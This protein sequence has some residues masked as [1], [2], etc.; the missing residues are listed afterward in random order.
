MQ[1]PPGAGG[2]SP[3]TLAPPPL[4]AEVTGGTIGTHEQWFPTVGRS[5]RSPMTSRTAWRWAFALWVLGLLGLL[6]GL[7]F[8]VGSG[9]SAADGATSVPAFLAIGTVGLLIVRRRPDNPIGWIY[10]GTW[11]GVGVAIGFLEGYGTWATVAHPGVPGGTLAVWLT[12][13]IWIPI[14]VPLVTYAFLLFPDGHVPSPR[15][16]PVAWAIPVSTVLWSVTFAL[17]GH[18]YTDALG[19]PAPNPYGI[20][21]LVPFFDAARLVFGLLFV[22]LIVASV[23][24]LFV[25][26]R[27]GDADERQQLKWLMFAG[28]IVAVWFALPL[29]HGSG[30]IADQIQG[31][32]LMLIPL[33][34][35]IAITKYHLYDIDLVVSKTVVVGVM[36]VFITLV[37]VGVVVGVGALVGSVGDPLLSAIAAALVAL[38]FQPV[39]RA[40][41]RLADRVVY[42]KR[43]TPYEV[44]AEFSSHMGETFSTEDVLQRMAQVLSAGTGAERATVWLRIQGELRPSA[45]WP[46]G[47]PA[48][49]PDG[50]VEVRDRGEALGALAIALPPSDPMDPGK[51]RLVRDL[52]SQAGLVLRNVRLIEELRASR[53]RLVAAQDAERR[54]IERNIHDGA[55]QD[56]VALAVRLRLA[57]QLSDRD[58]AKV[59]ELLGE[60]QAQTQ[61]ALENLR[62]LARGIYPPLLADR[63][64]GAALEAQAR[65]S[66]VPTHVEVDGVGRYA[67]QIE[68]TVYFC[69]L[70][71]MQ[72]VAKYAG[73]TSVSVSLE[74]LEDALT[75]RISDDGRGFDA[76]STAHGTGLQGM[77]D[78]L[79]AVGGTLEVRSAPGA[80]TTV[81]GRLPARARP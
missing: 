10:V 56:L 43:A 49:G 5:A 80:G 23:A 18:D 15:W 44:L 31:F 58:P 55:Q 8:Q 78:R 46:D 53:Q 68:A 69:A 3:A 17:E 24:S 76:A 79:D 33:A 66:P 35:G 41:H 42:G 61:D 34:S 50:S 26:F 60:L 72:N 11:T 47:A 25:R 48:A 14:F 12:N 6:G 4:D 29:E 63:G 13:W 71:A 73:A 1:A 32:I 59:R 19:R 77:A 62:D 27:R 65:K 67:A 52:A 9:Q 30:G 7:A 16:R 54:R 74:A 38:A 40:A 39:R 37:Y 75:F 28:A 36:A 81:V 51:E 2:D 22:W 20:A 45:T 21:G 70:E 64:L 57:E